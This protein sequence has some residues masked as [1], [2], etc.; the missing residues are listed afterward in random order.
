MKL[1]VVQEILEAEVLTG[2]KLLD[3]EVKN[4]CGADLM[5]DIL[6]D[7][8]V[9]ALLLTGLTHP[10][11]LQTASISDFAA[12]VIVRG[13]TPAR[14]LIELAKAQKMPLLRTHYSLYEACGMLYLAGLRGNEQRLKGSEAPR[15]KKVDARKTIELSYEVKGNDFNLAGRATEQAKK[16]LKQLGIDSAIARKVSIA[17]Y[18]AEM[19]IVIHAYRGELTFKISPQ[20]IEIIAV[21]QGPGIADVAKALREGYSTAPDRIRELGFGAGMGLPNMRKFSDEFEIDTVVGKGTKV[22]MLIHL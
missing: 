19:N 12:I 5:S 4:A 3:I 18:E 14:E 13:K 21:D 20:S 9:N 11:I 17:A 2:S 6:A 10:Q 15:D 8:K 22:T 1:A 7:T 16:V